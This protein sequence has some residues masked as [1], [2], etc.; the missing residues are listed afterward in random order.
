MA[1]K[2][3][4]NDKVNE[5]VDST[6]K[7]V[8]VVEE[9]TTTKSTKASKKDVPNKKAP[10]AS[11]GNDLKSELKKVTW[12]TKEQLF[13]STV[14]VIVVV[15]VITVIVFVLDVI[16]ESFNKFGINSLKGVISSQSQTMDVD[17]TNTI[18]NEVINS[19]AIENVVSE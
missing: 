17:L 12:L 14:A 3:S 1:K 5:P 19:D 18:S 7:E 15:L 4:N 10:K 11:K 13:N 2:K 16:F 8:E 9:K 6:E